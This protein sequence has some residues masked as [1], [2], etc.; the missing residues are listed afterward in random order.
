MR[1]M[2]PVLRLF[3]FC[4]TIASTAIAQ[5]SVSAD[6]GCRPPITRVR[7]HDDI[8][9][10]QKRLVD[11]KVN[12]GD[13]EDLNFF[14]NQA[15]TK[16]IDA[17][18]CMIDGDTNL[19]EQQKIAYLRGLEALLRTYGN[20][21]HA[22]QISASQFPVCLDAYEAAIKLNDK[23]ESILPLIEKYPYEVG[24]LLVDNL[25]FERNSG[26]RAAQ[27]HLVFKN[28]ELHPDRAF[29]ILKD[30][31]GKLDPVVRDSVITVAAYKNPRQAYDYAA[32][33][34]SLGFAI[35]AIKDPFVQ[36]ISKMAKSTSGQLYFPFLHN[37]LNNKQ[38]IAEIDEVKNDPVRY[39]K[40]LVKTKM[41]Y[42]QNRLGGEKV[43]EI[44]ALNAM[45][46][47]KALE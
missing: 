40:L 38:S 44:E 7:W 30:N 3:F 5:T 1:R 31:F 32:A 23:G 34:N 4:C 46:E 14:V 11:L 35:R 39:Y 19:R 12:A 16:R 33:D 18:Q 10:S 45:L 15:L 41:D 20:N 24:R 36:H 22:R 8:D 27:S 17:L 9:K 6:K 2:I 28:I 13:N 29:L 37:I 47:T 25:A 21:F 43:L 42:V 26:I